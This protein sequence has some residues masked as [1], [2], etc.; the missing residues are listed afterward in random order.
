MDEGPVGGEGE[1]GLEGDSTV[2]AE[3]GEDLG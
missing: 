3:L 2:E 1:R